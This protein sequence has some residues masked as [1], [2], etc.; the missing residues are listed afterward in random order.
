MIK[1]QEESLHTA[2]EMLLESLESKVLTTII[3][4]YIPRSC[5]I[6]AERHFWRTSPYTKY[7]GWC[8]YMPVENQSYDFKPVPLPS[9]YLGHTKIYG[10]WEEFYEL[11][12]TSEE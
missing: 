10:T 8:V 2:I 7:E 9:I 11:H 1:F 4:D 3:L 6:L 12:N 5:I